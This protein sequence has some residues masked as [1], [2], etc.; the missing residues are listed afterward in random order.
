MP[1]SKCSSPVDVGIEDAAA[2]GAD[3]ARPADATGG[4]DRI[5]GVAALRAARKRMKL[6]RRHG[7]QRQKRLGT[8]TAR[9]Q[10]V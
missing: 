8:E 7:E 1:S 2:I 4:I 6:G 10:I 5:A 3:E 9:Y